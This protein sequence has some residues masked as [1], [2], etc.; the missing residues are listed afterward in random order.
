[1]R[2]IVNFANDTKVDPSGKLI[3]TQQILLGTVLVWT[4]FDVREVLKDEYINGMPFDSERKLIY[5]SIKQMVHTLSTVKGSDQFN[6]AMRR[7]L[8]S[9]G[10]RFQYEDKQLFLL[11]TK[12]LAK[13][14]IRVR[15]DIRQ[16][17]IPTLE[18]EI[19]EV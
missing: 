12:N 4:N 16:Q 6:Q 13:Q 8:G 19:V 2:C 11:P 18:S 3:G 1:M 5:T 10:V 7:V 14:A 15:D 17:E 9:N